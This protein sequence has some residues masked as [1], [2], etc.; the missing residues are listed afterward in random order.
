MFRFGVLIRDGSAASS[1]FEDATGSMALPQYRHLI[2]ADLIVSAQYG[3]IRVSDA[4]SFGVT[5]ATTRKALALAIRSTSRTAL[6][7]AARSTSGSRVGCIT[8]TTIHPSPR[9]VLL[10]YE[11]ACEPSSELG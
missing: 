2:A 9:G 6:A 7:L 3:Q 10:R 8:A 5:S 4:S 1:G 11:Y